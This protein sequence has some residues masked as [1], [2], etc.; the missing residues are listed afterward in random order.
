MYKCALIVLCIVLASCGGGS[1]SDD[2]SSGFLGDA[3]AQLSDYLILDLKTGN[4]EGRVDFPGDALTSSKYRTSHMIF[5]R[6]EG[7]S[8]TG[9]GNSVQDIDEEQGVISIN[10]VFVAIFEAT[11]GQWE[12]VMGNSDTPWVFTG[13]TTIVPVSNADDIPAYNLSQEDADAF[14]KQ[15]D[16][17]TE[18]SVN[19]PTDDQWEYACRAGSTSLYSWGGTDDDT[20]S[21]EAVSI[22]INN[23]NVYQTN[24]EGEGPTAAGTGTA[25]TPTILREANPFGI[26]DMH[27]NVAEWTSD[28]SMRG[29]SWADTI[30]ICRSANKVFVDLDYVDVETQHPLAGVRLVINP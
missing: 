9:G 30:F 7:G 25:L 17:Q 20:R 23:V 14:A 1:T 21:S 6:V 16:S 18:Y 2:N 27:G 22:L 10:T 12:T 5:V 15:M 24:L 19:L 26:Y 8:V 28:N 11:Q 4:I 29:G 13:S 3:S